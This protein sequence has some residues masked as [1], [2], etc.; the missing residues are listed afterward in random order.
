M[1]A[2]HDL[3]STGSSND[4]FHPKI[5]TGH[6]IIAEVKDSHNIKVPTLCHAGVQYFVCCVLIA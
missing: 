5:S 3:I 6:Q 4:P 1:Y 2:L